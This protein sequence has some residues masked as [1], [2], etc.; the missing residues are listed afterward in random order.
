MVEIHP[1]DA[2]RR[3]IAAGDVVVLYN[4]RGECRLRA[5]LTDSVRPGVV[6]SPK[7]RWR[8]LSGGANVNVLTT[9]TLADLAGQSCYQSTRVWL[10]KA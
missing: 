4:D 5:V 7:G 6:A 8:K 3:G 2:A 10:R 1:D 9:D